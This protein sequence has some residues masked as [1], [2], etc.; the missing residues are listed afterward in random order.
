MHF[1]PEPPFG[2]TLSR[3]VLA[4]KELGEIVFVRTAGQRRVQHWR[5]YPSGLPSRKVQLVFPPWSFFPLLHDKDLNLQGTGSAA[6]RGLREFVACAQLAIREINTFLLS[7]RL[8]GPFRTPPA[9]RY[10]FTGLGAADTG[11]SG[12]R[13]VDLLITEK[14]IRMPGE[15][16]RVGVSYW[17]KRLGLA[18]N[19]RLRDIGRRSN[20]F[21]L[22]VSGAGTARAANFADV[23]FGVS[24]V[25]P[26]LVQGFLVPRGGTYVVQQPEIHLH[27]DAQ[28]VLADFFIYLASR[29]V[30]TI[31]E[32]HSE[33]LLLRLRRRLAEG[34]RPLR[35]GIPGE[36][37]EAA[38]TIDREGIS[39]VYLHEED[40]AVQI[41]PLEIGQ[42][43]QFENIPPG[44]MSQAVDDRLRLMRALTRGVPPKQRQV[45]R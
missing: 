15:P 1:K 13:A 24:Q 4:V 36:R 14:L 2:P 29:G 42:S 3:L 12:E 7:L 9:R 35:I 45:S 22:A 37:A 41:R 43:F 10:I 32:T 26:V 19:V 18:R 30:R 25:L 44:F 27:P 6:P 40:G 16:L 33:Y 11:S 20:I 31:V 5:A 17:L 38:V 28:A 34:V 23:G 39:V 21:E 8:L